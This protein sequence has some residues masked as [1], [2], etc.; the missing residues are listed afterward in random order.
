MPRRSLTVAHWV[1]DR[2]FPLLQGSV[3]DLLRRNAQRN[4]DRPALY[5][6]SGSGLASLSHAQVLARAT[7][8]AQWLAERTRPGDRIATWSRND[9]ELA[10]LH[11]ASALAGAIITP[12]NTGWADAEVLHAFALARPAMIVV[13]ADN[14]GQDLASRAEGLTELPVIGL[15]DLATLR[16]AGDPPLPV[17]DPADPYMIQFTSGTTGKAKGALLSHRAAILGG[18]LRPALEGGGDHDVYL[19]P[20]PMH[21]IGGS[22]AVLLGATALG[23]ANVVLDRYD[24]AQLIALMKPVGA[25]RMGGVPTI[26]FDLLSQP[27]LPRDAGVQ[28]VTLGG[29]SVPPQLVEQ[30]RDRLGARCAIGYGQS[31]C[32]IVTGTLPDD[33]AE[34]ITQTVG[35]PLPHVEVKIVDPATGRILA[36]DEVGELCVRAPTAMD[37]YYG[38]PAATAA[39]FDAEGFLRT[40]DLASMAPDGVCRIRGRTR[41]VII[42]G[43]E[44]IYPAEIENV[45]LELPEIAMAAVFGLDDARLGQKVAAAVTL[46]PGAEIEV[47]RLQAHV[48]A[49]VARFKVP[50]VWRVMQTLPMTASGKVRKHELALMMSDA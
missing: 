7:T 28:L 10:I 25:T 44:N 36:P 5:W 13:G 23:G 33:S 37:G 9:V 12:F 3:G 19:N 32:T 34:V 17:I 24:P 2:S 35:R 45:L 8:L 26:W 50:A 20:V 1:A 15:A 49:A 48:A 18:W 41:E 46:R 6:P 16:A 39:A 38:D 40:G 21:H 4:P 14:R 30:V 27:D 31:E 22:C 29:A 47:S 11:H 42:R 43:G